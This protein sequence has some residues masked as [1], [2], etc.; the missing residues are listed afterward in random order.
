[1]GAERLNVLFV[2]TANITRS[3]YTE[4][5]AR[6][7]L[8][9]S[10]VAV[11]SAGTPGYPGNEMDEGMANELRWRGGDPSGHLSRSVTRDLV[12]DA[13][14]VLTF[15]FAQGL[16]LIEAWPEFSGAIFGLGQFADAAWRLN[17]GDSPPSLARVMNA[18]QPNSMT[19][20]ILD[21]HLRGA[22]AARACADE[23][24]GLLNQILP[25]LTGDPALGLPTRKVGWWGG[26][27][28]V[29]DRQA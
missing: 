27:R 7:R 9:N 13:D 23:I 2:C 8:E 16:R 4:R 1:M 14:V 18:V 12:G 10:A 28:R 25:V 22:A 20:D 11:A 15:E 5:R 29:A 21:P 26:F 19:W 3:P 17:V 24:D 6:Q